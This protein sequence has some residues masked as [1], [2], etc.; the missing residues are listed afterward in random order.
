[1]IPLNNGYFE[2]GRSEV[3]II[4]PGICTNTYP[5][6]ST[7]YQHHWWQLDHDLLHRLRA[8]TIDSME[9][10]QSNKAHIQWFWGILNPHICFPRHLW[11][12]GNNMC[13]RGDS[14][15]EAWTGVTAP[16]CILIS[17]WNILILSLKSHSQWKIVRDFRQLRFPMHI[18]LFLV[19]EN[20]NG[21]LL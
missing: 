16:I 21:L 7:N 11:D 6:A 2:W 1:M 9:H 5:Y 19:I 15:A 13:F 20:F 4:Y 12:N 14:H 17:W 18:L 10:L 8:K 3:V